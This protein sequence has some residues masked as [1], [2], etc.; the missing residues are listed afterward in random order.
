MHVEFDATRLWFDVE[1]P[2]LVPDGPSMRERPTVVLVHGGPGGFDHSYFKPHFSWL[3]EH[4][5]VVY[6][7]L[8][9][10][11][12][13]EWGEAAA[14][15]FERCADDLR[16]FCDVLGIASP[17]VLG[18][19]MGAPVVLLYASRHPGHAAG[20][21][22][23]SGFARYDLDRIV[24]GFRR[25]GG[26]EIA[27]LARR[28]YDDGATVTAEEWERV[29]AVFGPRVPE[30]QELARRLRNAEVGAHGLELMRQLDVVDQL[31]RIRC[32][33]L[34]SVGELDPVT[35]VG[36]AEEVAAALPP[37]VARLEVLEGAG[38]FPWLDEPERC[39]RLLARFVEETFARVRTPVS[40]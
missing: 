15:S 1:G 35:P 29:F 23:Q 36:A 18:H 19:S 28:S 40:A 21:V 8:R 3:A 20:V 27:E 2:S 13:S 7:D 26:D 17:I 31:G 34:V 32:P 38:H 25:F 24:Q 33:T 11:G 39:R 37:G 12:R 14:W 9:G 6:L 10:H 22:V 4:A 30:K 16:G 5:Q